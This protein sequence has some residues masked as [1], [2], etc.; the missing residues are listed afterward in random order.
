M[1]FFNAAAIA[2][3]LL[4]NSVSFAGADDTA[5]INKC[6]NDNK[7]EG[8]SAD[9]VKSYCSCMNSKMSDNETASVTTWEK[10]HKKEADEC[11]K[12]AGWKDKK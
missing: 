4:M 11:S 6:V 12:Q 9:V 5:W 2:S 7:D 10:S 3:F 1:R 8:Q